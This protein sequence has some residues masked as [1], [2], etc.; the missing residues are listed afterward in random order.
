[1]WRG[2][3]YVLMQSIYGNTPIPY[4][5]RGIKCPLYP[6]REFRDAGLAFRLVCCGY[7]DSYTFSTAPPSNSWI[8][9]MIGLYIA[10]NGTPNIDCYWVGAVPNL[11]PT[12]F[13]LVY[14]IFCPEHSLYQ[15]SQPA[16]DV[17]FWGLGIPEDEARS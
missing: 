15:V 5:P 7:L 17:A 12:P 9:S 4:L 2:S 11:Y 10:L 6:R 16:K 3:V 14:V 13:F 8:T 1:M